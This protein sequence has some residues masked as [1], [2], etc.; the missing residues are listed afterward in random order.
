MLIIGVDPGIATVGVGIIE[1]D[2]GMYRAVEY[3]AI[4]T[5]PRQLLEDRLNQIYDKLT[6]IIKRHK[7]DCMAVEELFFNTNAKTALDV[8]QARGAI[9]LAA[10]RQGVDIY[11]YTPLQVKQSVVGYGRAEKHQVIYMTKLILKLKEDPKPDDTADALA[12][13]ICHGNFKMHNFG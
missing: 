5:K 3:G 1:A 11:E 10:K 12:I 2:N 6:D 13:A 9:L 8:A 4:I 7:P